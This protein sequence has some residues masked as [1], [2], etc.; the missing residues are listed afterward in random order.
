M[1]NEWRNWLWRKDGDTHQ[2]S[3]STSSETPGAPN[4]YNEGIH[5]ADLQPEMKEQKGTGEPEFIKSLRHK[6]I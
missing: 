5:P 3:T 4:Y 6:G 2:D 1:P